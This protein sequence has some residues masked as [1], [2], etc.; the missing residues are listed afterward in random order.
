MAILDK[1]DLA[2]YIVDKYY[3]EYNEEISPIKLQ[4]ALYF[5]FAMWGGKIADAQFS[6]Q[7][8]TEDDEKY[9]GFEK[10]LFDAN[11]EA[12]RYGPVDKE[13]YNMFKEGKLDCINI[14]LNKMFDSSRVS[15]IKE[16]KEY[17]DD[18]LDQIFRTNDFSL[19]DLSHEDKCWKDAI[20]LGVNSP[21]SN[22][23]IIK[24]YQSC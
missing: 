1:K 14:D 3:R 12:W 2:C 4:K 10:Y 15:Y 6:N 18:L 20:K 5:L 7:E 9:E 19:V 16:V 11:F 23:S 24:D 13:I 8:D 22:E 17:V 21:I